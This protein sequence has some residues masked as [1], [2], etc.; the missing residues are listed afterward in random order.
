[1]V[2]KALFSSASGEW[3][4]PRDLF[5]RLSDEFR[6]FTLDPAALPGQ[7]T[8]ERIRASGGF[9]CYPP[10]F[11]YY[12][13]PFGWAR[14]GLAQEWHGKVFLNPPYG[15]G[16]G[17]W[18]KKAHDEVLVGNAELV[19]AVLPARTDTRWWQTYILRSVD[20]WS[21]AYEYDADMSAADVRFLPGRLKFGGA[22]NPAPFP[23]AIV[24]WRH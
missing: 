9:A 1:M 3:E 18:V 5:E 20:A 6:G 14:D 22:E 10:D 17:A 4:T 19:V 16:I 12:R 11:P 24:V 2:D 13:V 8:A 15:R 7:Y 21:Q 23:S